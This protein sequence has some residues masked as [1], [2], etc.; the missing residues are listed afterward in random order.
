MWRVYDIGFGK[1]IFW[2][3][4]D[5]VEWKFLLMEII[6]LISE[7]IISFV[8]VRFRWIGGWM[9]V[10]EV[11]GNLDCCVDELLDELS[12]VVDVVD[13]C[14]LFICLEEGCV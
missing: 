3:K 7:I 10:I 1:N 12:V 2:I 5:V 11:E 13:N 8:L 6:F 9:F 14:W 4:F